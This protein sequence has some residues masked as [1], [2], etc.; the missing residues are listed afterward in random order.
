MPLQ[1]KTKWRPRSKQRNSQRAQQQR[2]NDRR[3][4]PKEQQ[5]PQHGKT[6]RHARSSIFSLLNLLTMALLSLIHLLVE[7]GTLVRECSFCKSAV[8]GPALRRGQLYWS[9]DE[10]SCN[11][12]TSILEGSIFRDDTTQCICDPVCDFFLFCIVAPQDKHTV[13]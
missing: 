7:T 4:T 9:C 11:K 10:R 5:S 12:R 1:S 2:P 3:Y 13:Y 6:K 8:T